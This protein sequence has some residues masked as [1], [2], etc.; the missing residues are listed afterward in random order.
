MTI[1]VTSE[2]KDI[3]YMP[4]ESDTQNTDERSEDNETED[5]RYEDN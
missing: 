3:E 4:V 5:E 2:D 1:V